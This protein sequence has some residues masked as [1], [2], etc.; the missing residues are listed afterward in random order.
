LAAYRALAP[1]LARLL[2]PGGT[3]VLEIGV[4]QAKEVGALLM[5]V[6][7]DLAGSRADLSGIE[8]ALIARRRPGVTPQPLE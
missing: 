7:L 6:G 2:R 3:A 8:R 1:E 5:A 4:G